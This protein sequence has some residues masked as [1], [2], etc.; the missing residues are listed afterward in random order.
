MTTH[1]SFLALRIPGMRETGGVPSMGSHRVRH[2]WSDL[3]AAVAFALHIEVLLYCMYIWLLYLLGLILGSL[4]SILLCFFSQSLFQ[5]LFYLTWVL[6]LL[7]SFGLHLN[8]ISFSSPSLSV[9]MCCLFW[10]GSLIDSIY[11]GFVFV[12]ISQSLSFGWGI[13]PIYIWGNYW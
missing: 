3:A 10:G 4:C 12:S 1:S 9:C 7:L 13:Q 11:R 8:E 5:I 6:L 2:D